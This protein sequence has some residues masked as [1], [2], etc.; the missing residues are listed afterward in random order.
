M[1]D[2][3]VVVELIEDVEWH[4]GR[5]ARG[6]AVYDTEGQ[7]VPFGVFESEERADFYAVLANDKA[8]RDER[9]ALSPVE[10]GTF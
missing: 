1:T 4:R 2:R 3:F 7:R 10:E 5:M 9:A 6:W 8:H